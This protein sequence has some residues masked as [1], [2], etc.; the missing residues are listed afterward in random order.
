VIGK[1]NASKKGK[2]SGLVI[3]KSPMS[4][5][6]K[7]SGL[8]VAISNRKPGLPHH[9]WYSATAILVFKAG[10]DQTRVECWREFGWGCLQCWRAPPH[11]NPLPQWGRGERQAM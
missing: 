8:K 7:E 11:P 6:G 5:A 4:Y 2:P 10:C 1:E 9:Q 3:G